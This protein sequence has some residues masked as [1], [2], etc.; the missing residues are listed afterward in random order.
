M[1]EVLLGVTIG[2]AAGISPG[3]LNLLVIQSTLRSG[4]GAGVLVA[5]SPLVTD[6]PI[7]ALSLVVASALPEVTLTALSV[8]GGLY[9]VWLGVAEWRASSE[10]KVEMPAGS[11]L[12]RGVITN[13]LSPH[14]W[15]FWLTVGGPTTVTAWQRTPGAAVGF[16]VAFFALMIGVKVVIA[17]LVARTGSRM[18]ER[19]RTRAARIGGVALVLVGLVV[20]AGGF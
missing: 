11:H 3:P 5:I 20:I 19:S 7:I 2:W 12:K 9:L 8:G 15:L 14:P 16:L 18:S 1:R 6:A 17:V 13:L 10:E 4:A